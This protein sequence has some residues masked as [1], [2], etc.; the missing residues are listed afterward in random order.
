MAFTNEIFKGAVF[1]SLDGITVSANCKLRKIFTLKYKPQDTA[2]KD[3]MFKLLSRCFTSPVFKKDRHAFG[4]RVF[5]FFLIHLYL[6][7]ERTFNM[8]SI[9]TNF[10][11][12]KCY[13]DCSYSVIQQVS[14][15]Y[16][17]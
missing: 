5:L 13:F 7:V 8:R 4:Q 1:Q 17:S 3:G 16:S 9:L 2:D 15:A 11:V 14:R 10:I 6:I 12:N